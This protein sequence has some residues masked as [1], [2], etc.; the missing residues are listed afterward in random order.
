MAIYRLYSDYLYIWADLFKNNGNMAVR[1][2]HN[3]YYT[4]FDHRRGKQEVIIGA[5]V[6]PISI[7]NSKNTCSI[8]TTSSPWFTTNTIW[9]F[10]I[11]S[12]LFHC[13]IWKMWFWIPKI[14]WKMWINYIIWEK[15][16]ADKRKN[17]E[18]EKILCKQKRP[19]GSNGKEGKVYLST[20]K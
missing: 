11:L 2:S 15:N 14:V 16:D 4:R 5:G 3:K 6:S 18:D 8:I 9:C 20:H 13:L 17:D 10:T 7:R 1:M 12:L 19:L